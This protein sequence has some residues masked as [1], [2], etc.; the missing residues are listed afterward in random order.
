MAHDEIG[1]DLTALLARSAHQSNSAK[2][3]NVIITP[4]LKLWHV[5]RTLELVY[6]D[7]YNSQLNDRYAG[8]R[9]QFR[10]MAQWARR[11]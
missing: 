9:D 7:A 6:G 1:V 10:A 5:Y 11:S 2:L 4:A 3:A 8:R